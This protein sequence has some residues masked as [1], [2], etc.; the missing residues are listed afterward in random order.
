M[1]DCYWQEAPLITAC[2]A[3]E[4]LYGAFVQQRIEDWR[5]QSGQSGQPGL[6]NASS[7]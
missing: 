1:D 7:M 5:R 6:V 2:S 3:A 4:P